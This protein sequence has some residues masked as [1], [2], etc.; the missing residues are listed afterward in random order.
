MKDYLNSWDKKP[1]I[2]R[3]E[4]FDKNPTSMMMQQLSGAFKKRSYINGSYIGSWPFAVYI[5]ISG[6]DTANRLDAT[7]TLNG[8]HE[9]LTT[10]E[11]NVF[12]N[13][14]YLGDDKKALKIE[15]TSLPSIAARYDDGS[16]DYQAIYELEYYCQGGIKNG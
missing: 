7:G 15:M 6:K 4:A 1:V 12:T 10:T 14:P 2:I 11:N 3:L 16:E 9:W 5:R 8:L 13:L